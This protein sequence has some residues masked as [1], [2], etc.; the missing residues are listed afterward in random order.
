MPKSI[1]DIFAAGEQNKVDLLTGWNDDDGDS[2][3]TPENAE[4]F[5]KFAIKKYGANAEKFLAFY[6]AHNDAEAMAS[7]KK[8]T[9]YLA[10]DI[11]N[12]TWAN[13]QSELKNSKVYVY[14]FARQLPATEDYL[15]Y[16][17]FHTGEVAYAY[18][19]LNFVK[20]CPWLPA[21]YILE[22]TMLT[23]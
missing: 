13:K 5:K 15:K 3:R 20:R 19:N 8:F 12:Y 6:P 1:P 2:F 14:S 7:Q 17:A 16:G 18:G 23:Y 4:D 9:R 21:D 10:A 22:N 11:Q